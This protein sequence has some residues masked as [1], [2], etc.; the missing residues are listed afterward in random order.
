MKKTLYPATYESPQAE[1][2][3]LETE[4]AILQGSYLEGVGHNSFTEGDDILV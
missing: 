3:V 2:M 4:G 1:V